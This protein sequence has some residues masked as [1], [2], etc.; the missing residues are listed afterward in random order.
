MRRRWCAVERRCAAEQRMLALQ[1][2]LW[3]L[4]AGGCV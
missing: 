4:T 3:R 1:M 2:P